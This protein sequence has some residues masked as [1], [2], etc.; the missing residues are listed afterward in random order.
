MPSTT[1]YLVRHGEQEPA[2]P[3][4]SP[5]GRDQ[6]KKLAHR[7]ETG[8]GLATPGLDVP[9]LSAARFDAVHHSALPRAAQTA[10]ILSEAL[11]GVPAHAC[12]LAADRT[13]IP[14]SYPARYQEFFGQVPEEERDPDATHLRAA[15][16][17]LS[18]IGES[19]RTDLVV[20]H[21]FVIG[22]F[23]RHVLQAPEW[24]WLGLNQANCGMTVLRW[25]TGRP[26]AL[27]SFNDTGHL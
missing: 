21:N 8:P 6:A 22:W 24:R 18:A 5:Q 11:P 12:D 25:E 2:G 1:L 4:L 20:T 13:P 27:L 7:L 23:V 14:A 16:E 15:V 26:A 10:E 17:S 3:N 9:G 19:D